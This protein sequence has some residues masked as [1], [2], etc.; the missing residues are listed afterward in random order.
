MYAKFKRM[1]GG[2]A[3]IRENNR[4]IISQGNTASG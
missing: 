2:V 4:R 1:E 3:L